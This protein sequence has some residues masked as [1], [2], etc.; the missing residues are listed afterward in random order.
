MELGDAAPIVRRLKAHLIGDALP[1]ETT[2]GQALPIMKKK[3]A[4]I[5][6]VTP[7]DGLSAALLP[8]APSASSEISSS[9]SPASRSKR[10]TR[11]RKT[12]TPVAPTTVDPTM[13]RRG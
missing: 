9:A 11:L 6:A 2:R 4:R 1:W 8:E 5:A 12:D 10:T 7:V 3:A 13:A